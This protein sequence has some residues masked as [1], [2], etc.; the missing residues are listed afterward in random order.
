[1]L[2]HR[3]RPTWEELQL[4]S[5]SVNVGDAFNSVHQFSIPVL[6]HPE[7][8]ARP[9]PGRPFEELEVFEDFDMEPSLG[10]SLEHTKE[11]D[12]DNLRYV[13]V[14]EYEL[15]PHQISGIAWMLSKENKDALTG[16]G[17]VADK[18]GKHSIWGTLIVLPLN[19]VFQWEALY[20]EIF[21]DLEIQVYHGKSK[22]L[23]EALN[24]IGCHLVITTYDTIRLEHATEEDESSGA[25]FAVRWRRIIFDEAHIIRNRESKRAAAC[26]AL[27]QNSNFVWCLTATPIQ[28]TV[29]DIYSLLLVLNPPNIEDFRRQIELMAVNGD[30]PLVETARRKLRALLRPLLLR[31]LR[32]D[33]VDGEKILHLKPYSKRPP[34]EIATCELDAN[35][36]IVYEM[37]QD[38]IC[39]ILKQF[40]HREW[41][42]KCVFV[43][44]LR[45]R[46][47]CLHPRLLLG[48]LQRDAEEP[49]DGEEMCELNEASQYSDD[50]ASEMAK[51]S[52]KTG[53]AMG[54][55]Q[56]CKCG[57][58][59]NDTY[60]D[61]RE[62][63]THGD[64]CRRA[65]RKIKRNINT[66]KI[67]PSSR[68]RDV[69]T[70]LGK[71]PD[72]ERTIVFSMF[73][74]FLM[75]LREVLEC[76]AYKFKCVQYDGSMDR[77]SRDAA[78]DAIK[79]GTGGVNIILMSM[80]AGSSAECNHVIFTDIW[81][82]PAVEEQA[83]GRVHRMGQTRKVYVHKLVAKNTIESRILAVQQGKRELA[84]K[85]LARG[86]NEEMGNITL[87]ELRA[88]AT[89]K[90][91]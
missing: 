87:E 88:P 50:G 82:N 55:P 40:G 38:C 91:S 15:K 81:W 26:F 14:G 36:R 12:P 68:M 76:D 34:R 22:P 29:C 67:L 42:T 69:L 28:N 41:S 48:P 74:S 80:M 20:R 58:A 16:G 35:E 62:W 44:I 30:S 23:L 52:R 59:L 47:A 8:H 72:G 64:S 75:L 27:S 79:R 11:Q 54:Y 33:K 25:L 21:L 2:D 53:E 70:I 10:Q 9:G 85:V 65:W 78:L 63:Q 19:L 90:T 37:L 3:R 60:M 57:L 31:R 39:D 77:K 73:P 71:V 32:N 18:V 45:L 43:L 49:L 46:Q 24:L 86:R 61:E 51:T 56:S 89:G 66:D 84:K 4:G 7:N 1:M 17:I 13:G 83:I 5:A 6:V